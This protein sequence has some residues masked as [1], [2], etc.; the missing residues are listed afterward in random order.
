[1]QYLFRGL[2]RESGEPVEGHVT[3]PDEEAAYNVLGD[4][5]IVVGSLTRQPALARSLDDA[6]DDAGLPVNFDRLA[7]R[8]RGKTVWVLDRDRIR[9]RVMKLVDEAIAAHPRDDEGRLDA[10]RHIAEVLE[11]MFEDRRN[12]GSQQAV[13]VQVSH[14]TSVVGQMEKALASMSRQMRRSGRGG[15]R[16]A[17][18]T[19]DRARDAVLVEV[20]ETNLAL[21]RGMQ[22]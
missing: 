21:I 19:R 10:R 4:N 2:R 9:Q 12:L 3:V 17:A 18:S 15:P 16:R 20:F 1:M 5:G 7:R 6:L 14:L 11:R 8:Y 13:Q 22:A